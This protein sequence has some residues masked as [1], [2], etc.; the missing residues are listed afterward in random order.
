MTDIPG[1]QQLTGYR[2]TDYDDLIARLG[3][4]TEGFAEV[5]PEHLAGDGR[6]LFETADALGYDL[7]LIPREDG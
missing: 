6:R 1:R 5:L 2:L 4:G 3:D 7:A